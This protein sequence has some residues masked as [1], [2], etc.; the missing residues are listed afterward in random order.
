MHKVKIITR[1][2]TF[3][4]FPKFG[5]TG[6]VVTPSDLASELHEHMN[7]LIIFAPFGFLRFAY[8]CTINLL[9]TT[10]NNKLVTQ[11]FSAA[12]NMPLTIS[13]YGSLGSFC[14]N[15]IFIQLA[16]VYATSISQITTVGYGDFSRVFIP[17]SLIGAAF[18]P[19]DVKSIIGAYTI[20][21][22]C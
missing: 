16:L 2:G 8:N 17:P 14:Y 19:D 21:A 13:N 11:E 9:G 4:F 7:D 20:S 1:T 12:F 10:T 18:I 6:E 22:E 3:I 15:S 5:A